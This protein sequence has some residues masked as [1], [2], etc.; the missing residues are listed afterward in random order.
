MGNFSDRHRGISKIVDSVDILSMLT[1]L[2]N[3]RYLPAR[4]GLWLIGYGWEICS[5]GG[6][7]EN[8]QVSRY[9]I[10]TRPSS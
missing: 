5:T 7:N 2:V 6:L 8:L 9:S 4:T 3:H 1:W 10:T